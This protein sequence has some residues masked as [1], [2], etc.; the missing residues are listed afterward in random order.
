MWA[1]LDVGAFE[2]SMQKHTPTTRNL[3]KIS[4]V[5]TKIGQPITLVLS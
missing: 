3:S 5:L 2:D 1:T 4:T